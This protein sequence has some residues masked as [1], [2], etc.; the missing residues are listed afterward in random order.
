MKCSYCGNTLSSRRVPTGKTGPYCKPLYAEQSYCPY[1]EWKGNT[2][3]GK[4][5]RDTII[6]INQ[7]RR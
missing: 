2:G 5:L 3:P 7:G 1:C 6:I 4:W